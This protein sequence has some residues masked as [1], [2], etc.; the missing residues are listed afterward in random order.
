MESAFRLAVVKREER[1]ASGELVV[2]QS[3]RL[4]KRNRGRRDLLGET[5]PLH[6]DEAVNEIFEEDLKMFG[7]NYKLSVVPPACVVCR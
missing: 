6:T 1:I 7:K 4:A 3:Y 2:K 5:Q